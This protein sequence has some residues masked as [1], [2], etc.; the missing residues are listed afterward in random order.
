M[1]DIAFM[2][3]SL[4]CLVRRSSWYSP[5]HGVAHLLPRFEE[6]EQASDADLTRDLLGFPAPSTAPSKKPQDP[7]THGIDAYGAR[8]PLAF[9]TSTRTR[10]LRVRT[11]FSRRRTSPPRYSTVRHLHDP[12]ANRHAS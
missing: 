3:A 1:T 2:K 5:R 10:G 8:R 4:T 7:R 11:N 9:A 12:R 6:D